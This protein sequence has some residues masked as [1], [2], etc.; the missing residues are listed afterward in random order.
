MLFKVILTLESVDEIRNC[1]HSN[2]SY[3]AV[4]SC[5]TVLYAVLGGQSNFLG[6]GWNPN[7]CDHS[8][9][10]SYLAVLSSGL[11]YYTIQMNATEQYEVVL[12]F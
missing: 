6:C 2:E 9:Y 1:D 7:K 10:E 11:V 5:G 4:L 3:L 12:T 8:N